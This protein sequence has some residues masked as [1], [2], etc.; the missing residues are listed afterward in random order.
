MRLVAKRVFQI[1]DP[2]IF[3]TIDCHD[4]LLRDDRGEF[5]LHTTATGLGEK[6]VRLNAVAAHAWL[7]ATPEE[8]GIEWLE[9]SV[10]VT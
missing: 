3:D 6:I 8:Y 5:I 7:N 1:E 9:Q 4:T 2:I 10:S